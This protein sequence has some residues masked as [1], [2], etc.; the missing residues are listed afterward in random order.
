M[1]PV[2]IV[3]AVMLFGCAAQA[4]PPPRTV[5]ALVDVSRSVADRHIYVTG[6]N[7]LTAALEPNQ[8]FVLACITDATYVKPEVFFDEAYP[9]CNIWED[10]RAKCH[11]DVTAFQARLRQAIDAVM[12]H[13]KVPRTAIM[14]GALLAGKVLGPGEAALIVFFTDAIEDSDRANFSKTAPTLAQTRAMID[15]QRR[16]QELPNLHGTVVRMIG[17]TSAT[18]KQAVAIEQFWIAWFRATSACVDRTAF[19]PV[20]GGPL[21]ADSGRTCRTD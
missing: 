6:I 4:A 7:Q 9:R 14:D 8:R 17:M 11:N 18:T 20:T 15:A 2:L 19:T 1:K 5:M 21:R 16:N 3:L 12:A 13:G 10:N